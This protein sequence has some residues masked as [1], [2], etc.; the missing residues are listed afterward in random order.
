MNQQSWGYL[1][2]KL[3]STLKIHE[4]T[5]HK[6]QKTK[7]FCLYYMHYEMSCFCTKKRKQNILHKHSQN[8]HLFTNFYIF[9]FISTQ[10]TD[11]FLGWVNFLSDCERDILELFLLNEQIT[12]Y[13]SSLNICFWFF[14]LSSTSY[15]VPV[16]L[17]HTK[18][19]SNLN[20]HIESKN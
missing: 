2:L 13:D 18:K 6:L 12:W 3:V 17:Y 16:V 20:M 15:I 11:F 1:N 8:E 7:S 5:N 10:L 9:C 19:V 4:I 14:S